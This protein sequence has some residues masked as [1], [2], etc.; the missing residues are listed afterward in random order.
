M[1]KRSP[2][3]R[4]RAVLGVYSLHDGGG[5]EPGRDETPAVRGAAVRALIAGVA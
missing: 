5:Q 3:A 1:M 2:M 4:A